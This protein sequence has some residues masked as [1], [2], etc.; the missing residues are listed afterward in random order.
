MLFRSAKLMNRGEGFVDTLYKGSSLAYSR[1]GL[2]LLNEGCNEAWG[3]KL[4]LESLSAPISDEF[5]DIVKDSQVW[6]TWVKLGDCTLSEN[7]SV[8]KRVFLADDPTKDDTNVLVMLSPQQRTKSNP[9][10]TVNIQ[11]LNPDVAMAPTPINVSRFTGFEWKEVNLPITLN[12][13]LDA[14]Q[15]S[16]MAIARMHDR[17]N[18][19]YEDELGWGVGDSR[20]PS[21]DLAGKFPLFTKFCSHIGNKPV[22][23]FEGGQALLDLANRRP[24]MVEKGSVGE[25]LP[26]RVAELSEIDDFSNEGMLKAARDL[27]SMALHDRMTELARAQVAAKQNADGITLGQVMEDGRQFATVAKILDLTLE[28]LFEKTTPNIIGNREWLSYRVWVEGELVMDVSPNNPALSSRLVSL[29]P[30]RGLLHGDVAQM[31]SEQCGELLSTL[32]ID[33]NELGH[34][35]KAGEMPPRVL[36]FLQSGDADDYRSGAQDLEGGRATL[37][38]GVCVEVVEEGADA[39]FEP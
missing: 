22:F 35:N 18:L 7:D 25:P 11:L 26:L 10:T 3:K 19:Q 30:M 14:Y 36:R 2:G 12:G 34:G 20:D 17:S 21:M 9:H 38:D 23:I 39:A 28:A 8:I 27:C 4:V 13:L 15:P 37:V 29:S 24:W 31:S 1:D 33:P 32:L 6:K 5:L 16:T